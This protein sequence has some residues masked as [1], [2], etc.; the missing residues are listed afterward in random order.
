MD[1]IGTA[2]ACG[3]RGARGHAEAD[4]GRDAAERTHRAPPRCAAAT[5]GATCRRSTQVSLQR[6]KAYS[7]A[8]CSTVFYTLPQVEH[9]LILKSC[10]TAARSA[11][12][13]GGAAAREEAAALCSRMC[14]GHCASPLAFV[15]ALQL[16]EEEAEADAAAG[17]AAAAAAAAAT[18][19][20]SSVEHSSA[21]QRRQ[22][23]A[24]LARRFLHQHPG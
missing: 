20:V 3:S 16:A 12:G 10:G 2:A 8:S 11:N 6:C 1:Y 18:D 13:D 21:R 7:P 14:A 24:S 15:T 4:C 5:P 22:A 19:G 17:A 23:T 9:E